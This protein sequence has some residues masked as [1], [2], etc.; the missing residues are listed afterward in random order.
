MTTDIQRLT[1]MEIKLLTLKLIDEK[2]PVCR[3]FCDYSTGVT[4][5]FFVGTRHVI[6]RCRSLVGGTSDTCSA[7]QSL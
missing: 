5:F 7:K 4:N 6:Q 3:L 2:K 1:D